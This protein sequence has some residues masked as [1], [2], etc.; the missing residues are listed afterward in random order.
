MALQLMFELNETNSSAVTTAGFGLSLAQI[1]ELEEFAR[2]ISL[3]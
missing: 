2:V 3:G 1:G